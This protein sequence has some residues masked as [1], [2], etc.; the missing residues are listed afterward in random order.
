MNITFRDITKDN[1]EDIVSLEMNE[2]QKGFVEGPMYSI[3]ECYVDK[4]WIPKAIYNDEIPVGFAFYSIETEPQDHAFL[5]RLMIDKHFQGT[6]LGKASVEAIVDYFKAEYPQI[7]YVEL[8]HY[9][10]N[11]AGA[12]LYDATGFAL[13]GEERESGPCL[14]EKGTEN[15]LRYVELVRRRDY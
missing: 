1:F 7:K 8:I 5:H 15:D 9:K 4:K 13:T 14:C 10:D 6:G 3:A 11:A 2:E 12:R